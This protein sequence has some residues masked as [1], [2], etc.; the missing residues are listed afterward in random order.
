MKNI[1]TLCR[2]ASASP[3]FPL[4]CFGAAI[5][6]FFLIFTR[7]FIKTDDGHFL[8]IFAAP[9]FSYSGW[10]TERYN[11][12]SGRTVGEFLLAFF[13]RRNIVWWQIFTSSAVTYIVWFLFKLSELFGS[14]QSAKKRMTFCCC[15][16]FLIFISCL[17][18]SVF[19][20]SGTF[21]YVL[22]FAGMLMAT[23]PLIFYVL[24][25]KPSKITVAAALPAAF[26]GTA[27][28]QAAVCTLALFTVLAAVIIIKKLRFKPSLFVPLIPAALCAFFLLTSP[29]ANKRA[30]IEA[31]GAFP[32]YP[33][34]SIFEKLYCG[35]SVFFANSYFLSNFLILVLIALL[36]IVLY[37]KSCAK[38]K[39]LLIMLNILCV[40]ICTA[41]NYGVSALGGGLAHT[42]IRKAFLLGDFSAP[43]C[44]LFACGCILTFVILFLSVKLILSDAKTGLSASLCLAAGFGCAL[45]MSFTPSIFASGQRAYFFTNMFTV[46]A[47]AVLFSS[48]KE[49][50]TS[51]R[52][53]NACTV[54]ATLMFA[55]NCFAFKFFEHPL[56]G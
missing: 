40:V 51:D 45:M 16:L 53:L 1:K 56:M 27:Q 17:N 54:Y 12:V 8:G 18:P 14:K 7:H 15:G 46:A 21:T 10:L 49:S 19:W 9:D 2:K 39:N 29:G 5:T 13:A 52:I 43:F 28:E 11:T 36:S 4:A 31:A 48:A 34:M 55:V 42:V 6:L 47:C 20:F 24:G 26:I 33:D 35:V 37:E 3:Y 22:P 32:A 44:V 30:G 38:Q 25:G 23:A 50:K 41:V